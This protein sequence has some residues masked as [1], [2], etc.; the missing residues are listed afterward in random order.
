M[1]GHETRNVDLKLAEATPDQCLASNVDHGPVGSPNCLGCLRE[2]NS[3]RKLRWHQRYFAAGVQQTRP[4]HPTNA[5]GDG[6][7]DFLTMLTTT[8]GP[9]VDCR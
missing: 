4:L 5:D 6:D 8:G 1:V 7:V 2:S 3:R 9:A